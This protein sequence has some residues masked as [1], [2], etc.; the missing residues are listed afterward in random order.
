MAEVEIT[1]TVYFKIADR[2]LKYLGINSYFF[3]SETDIRNY[4]TQLFSAEHEGF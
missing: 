1:S 3:D 2:N 4:L